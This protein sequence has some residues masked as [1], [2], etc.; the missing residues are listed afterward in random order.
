MR[1][2]S[3]TTEIDFAKA[4]GLVPAIVQHARSG[5]VLM[6]GYMNQD[7]LTTT[8]TEGRVTFFSRSKQRLWQKGESSGNTLSVESVH[9]DCDRDSI[10]I[11]ALPA[12]PTCHL[13][14]S[15]CFSA[16]D[17]SHLPELERLQQRIQA[18]ASSQESGSYTAKLLARGSKRCA[19]KVGEEGVEVALA[20]ATENDPELLNESADLLYH[21]L[22]TLESRG[23]SLNQV[24]QVLAERRTAASPAAE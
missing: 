16:D 1:I 12:G 13:G 4:N 17:L 18:R 11:L 6:Q 19:Q 8:L 14:S 3:N 2:T 22:V 20:A 10:L 7:A 15:S 23:Q 5:E 21:L 9:T 24:L